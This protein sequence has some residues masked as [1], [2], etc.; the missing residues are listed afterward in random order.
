MSLVS[1]RRPASSKSR[2]RG[3]FFD[4]GGTLLVNR[5]DRVFQMFLAEAGQKVDLSMVRLAYASIEPHWL[6]LYG[7]RAITPDETVEAYRQKDVLAYREL[8]HGA[9]PE[10][11]EAFTKDARRRWQVI[12]KSVPYELYP[13]AEPTLEALLDGGYRLGLVSNAPAGT[14]EVVGSLGLTRY[15]SAVVISGAVGYAKPHPEIFRIA[16]RLT[17]LEPED[18]VHVGDIFDSDVLGARSAGIRGIL[19]DRD[20]LNGGRDCERVRTLLDLPARI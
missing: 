8:F 1:V 3:I 12:E 7:N 5:R 14:S 13:D 10:T 17:G 4:L 2:A 16:L 9:S 20:D 19:L 11:V 18:T 15:L 6:S